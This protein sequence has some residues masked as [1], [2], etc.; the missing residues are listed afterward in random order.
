M[1]TGN[2][3]LK[4]PAADKK[5]RSPWLR[6]LDI[7]MRTAHI[8]TTSVLF[9]GAVFML[10]FGQLVSWHRVAV[11]SGI[12]LTLLGINQSRHWF[13]QVRGV[14]TICHVGLLGLVHPYPQYRTQIVATALVIGCIISHMPGSV[15]HWSLFHWR[16]TE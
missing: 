7:L 13:Y 12:V 4:E 8:A 16:K 15:R 5:H 6:A 3:N 2:T 1:S 14:M 11:A 9:G 10:P